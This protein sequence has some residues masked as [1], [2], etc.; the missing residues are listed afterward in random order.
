MID[1]ALMRPAINCRRIINN[2]NNCDNLWFRVSRSKYGFIDPWNL[3]TQR[4]S[5]RA[6][7]ALMVDFK[8]IKPHL[9]KCIDDGNDTHIIN[10]PWCLNVPFAFKPTFID[11][12][13]ISNQQVS[14]LILNNS[15]DV[16]NIQR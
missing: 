3:T 15:W 5:S 10:Q 12:G 13:S 4:K 9:S 2:L 14:S 7:K 6:W 16:S 1:P 11:I 8:L